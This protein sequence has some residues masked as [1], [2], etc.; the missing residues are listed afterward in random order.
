MQVQP[1]ILGI[2]GL[3]VM[4]AEAEAEEMAVNLYIIIGVVTPVMLLSIG[5]IIKQFP[6]GPEEMA[7]MVVP[8]EMAE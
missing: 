1:A 2:Q 4:E 6:E 3:R 8:E 5:N 7:D